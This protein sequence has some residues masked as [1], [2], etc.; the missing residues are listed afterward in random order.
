MF[1][2]WSR[3]QAPPPLIGKFSSANKVLTQ[4]VGVQILKRVVSSVQMT[5]FVS[6]AQTR[7]RGIF[8]ANRLASTDL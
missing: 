4:Y 2:N 6:C 7:P 1:K 8:V 5:L 3:T